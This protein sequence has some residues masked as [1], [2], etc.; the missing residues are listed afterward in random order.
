MNPVPLFKDQLVAVLKQ[1]FPE[2]SV[3]FID[4]WLGLAFSN[5]PGGL[6]IQGDKVVVRLGSPLREE[7]FDMNNP[8]FVDQLGTFL[9]SVI[10]GFP[11]NWMEV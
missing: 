4:N 5:V 8:A 3:Y 2:A 10:P 9:G 6:A 11:D 7:I 1:L